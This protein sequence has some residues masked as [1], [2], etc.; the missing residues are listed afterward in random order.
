MLVGSAVLLPALV[1]AV[2]PAGGA[3]AALSAAEATVPARMAG[4]SYFTGDVSV[5]APGRAVAL[6]QHG[7]GVECMDFPQAV[8]VSADRDTYRR[9]DLAEDRAGAETQGDPA[10]MLL[11]PDGTRIAVGRHDTTQPD[12]AVLDL[13]TGDVDLHPLP[14]G[15]SVLP[16]AWSLDGRRVAYL[17][18]PEPT[19]PYSG[20]PIAGEVGLL[21]LA[22]DQAAAM[23][24]ASAVWTAAFS[25]DGTELAVQR[26]A[27]A[28]ASLEVRGLDGELRRSLDL[29][30]GHHLDGPDAWSPDG[31]LLA[32]SRAPFPCADAAGNET[33]WRECRHQHDAIPDDISFVDAT[34]GDAPVPMPL[35]RAVVGQG[36]VLGWASA[37]EVFVLAGRADAEGTDPDEFWVTRVPLDGGDAQQLSAV[38]T[39]GG[40]YGIGRFQL[41]AALLPD[42]RVREAGDLD[43]GPW[44]VGLRI[45]TALVAGAVAA[46][47]T[48][49][50][51][52]TARRPH[53]AT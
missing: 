16:V 15:R 27:A 41:A 48:A 36:R 40:N 53:L 42:L 25:P 6:F 23:P 14:A 34:G 2:L 39:S 37:R 32:T 38:P 44:P 19:N 45:A 52:R 11:S 5:S 33:Q 26:A 8:V 31:T 29:P 12:L 17:S 49:L 22:A 43:R 3:G 30:A 24:G 46:L 10:P 47:V 20:T 21:D 13:A 18:G 51:A 7:W 9:V 4:Y 28:G 50:L 35:A 1:F